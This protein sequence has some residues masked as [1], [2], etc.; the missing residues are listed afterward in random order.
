[1]P[2]KSST[3]S[4]PNATNSPNAPSWVLDA[5]SA[6]SAAVKHYRRHF[7]VDLDIADAQHHDG[8]IT[9]RYQL[10]DRTFQPDAGALDEDRAVGVG[11]RFQTG[12]PIARLGGQRA[13]SI[14]VGLA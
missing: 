9:G 8:V 11:D 13:R 3:V 10:L 5:E 4:E 1:M 14:V 12:E 2:R 6:K 7:G